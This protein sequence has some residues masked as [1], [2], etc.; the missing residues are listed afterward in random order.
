MKIDIKN[1]CHGNRGKR[2]VCKVCNA[3]RLAAKTRAKRQTLGELDTNVLSQFSTARTPWGCL[4]CDVAICR[5]ALC[6]DMFHECKIG[7]E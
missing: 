3:R 7:V 4:D 5:G 1:H 6:R 2:A